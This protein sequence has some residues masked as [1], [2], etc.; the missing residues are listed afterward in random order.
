M[1]ESPSH[2]RFWGLDFDCPTEVQIA[3][4]FPSSFASPQS[5]PSLLTPQGSRLFDHLIRP[6]Q[7][8]DGNCQTNLFCRFEVNDEFKLRCLLHWQITRFGTF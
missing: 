8:A 4:L 6:L 2:L 1:T 7:H 3:T 5:Q